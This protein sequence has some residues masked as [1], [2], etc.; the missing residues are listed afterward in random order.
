MS[1]FLNIISLFKEGPSLNFLYYFIQGF[2]EH[3][4]PQYQPQG[5]LRVS[6]VPSMPTIGSLVVPQNPKCQS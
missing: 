4:Y 5:F 6:S 2:S 3:H 1:Y